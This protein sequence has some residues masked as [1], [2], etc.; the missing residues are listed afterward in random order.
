LVQIKRPIGQIAVL[1][2]KNESLRGSESKGK[3]QKMQK[4]A[5]CPV[6]VA[7]IRRSISSNPAV[8]FRRNVNVM[9]GKGLRRWAGAPIG[10]GESACPQIVGGARSLPCGRG[11]RHADSPLTAGRI[12]PA[13]L[14]R[15]G[16][17]PRVA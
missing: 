17:R 6:W 12:C 14:P 2:H 7:V 3:S 15:S 13:N 8:M 11:D 4:T 5:K 16:S 9:S 1:R 10:C